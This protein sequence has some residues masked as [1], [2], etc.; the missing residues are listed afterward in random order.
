MI[1][2]QFEV[3]RKFGDS[4]WETAKPAQPAMVSFL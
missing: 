2:S 4:K 3:L 1:T